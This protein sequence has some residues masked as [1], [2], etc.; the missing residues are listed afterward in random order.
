MEGALQN[1][2]CTEMSKSYAMPTMACFGADTQIPGEQSG[3]ERGVGGMSVFMSG[4]D[5]ISGVGLTGSAQTLYLEELVLNEDICNMCRRAARGIGGGREHALTELVKAVGPGGNFLAEASTVAYLK[6][7]EHLAIK[8]FCRDNYE[9][10]KAKG[11]KNEIQTA[12]EKVER[13]LAA[14]DKEN[15]SA[16]QRAGLKQIMNRADANI[17]EE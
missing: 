7:G 3:A 9:G 4:A 17:P 1:A 8:N 10:W 15:F 12:Q 14:H 16:Q 5:L 13:I 11:Q 6:N 2:A